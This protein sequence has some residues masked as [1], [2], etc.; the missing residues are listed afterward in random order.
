MRYLAPWIQKDLEKKM[1]FLSGPRQCGKTT[2]ALSLLKSTNGLGKSFNWDRDRDRKA[3]LK[4]QWT[5]EDRLLI[6]DEIHKFKR[7]KNWVK[8]I[9]DTEKEKHSILVTGSARLDVY[10]HWRLHPFSLHESS[11]N[12]TKAEV[13]ERLMR[14]GGFPEPFLD[15]SERTARRWRSERQDH[16]LREDLRDIEQ[17]RDI[18][19][20]GLLLDLLKT[21]V[22]GPIVVSN[23]AEDLQVAPA[24]VSKWIEMLERMYVIFT[25][26]PYTRNIAR[27]IQKPPKIYFFDTGDVEGDEGA[28]FEN[29]VATH[30]LKKIHYLN[31]REGERYEL[32]YIRDKE[33]REVDF[34][35]T[36]SHGIEALIEVKWSDSSPSRSLI[37]FAEKLAPS[38]TIQLVGTLEEGFT[39]NR[40]QIQSPFTSPW[41]NELERL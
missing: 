37:H 21:R 22:G 29:L 33:K 20:M 2:L 26:R 28:R 8:G 19:T 32:Q 3:L 12:L 16:I 14:V 34:I 31:D 18:Q 9:Y 5:D 23:L 24:T 4:E 11:A 17:V 36:R 35:I 39:K 25:V 41:L 27:A 38:Q 40:L 30:L 6:F 10:H 7:W 1:V 13:F 15:G